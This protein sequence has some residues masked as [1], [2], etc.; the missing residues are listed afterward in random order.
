[1]ERVT[2]YASQFELNHNKVGI[3]LLESNPS[4]ETI[5][6]A[7][8]RLVDLATPSDCGDH[9][10][11][12]GSLSGGLCA[13]GCLK[14]AWEAYKEEREVEDSLADQKIHKDKHERNTQ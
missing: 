7:R 4:L 8:T 13:E 5:R 12:Q 2:R 14:R 1:M 10:K 9:T 11:I 6:A 3:A